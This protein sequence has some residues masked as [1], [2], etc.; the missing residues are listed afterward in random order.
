MCDIHTSQK[1]GSV[2]RGIDNNSIAKYTAGKFKYQSTVLEREVNITN[3]T[4][5]TKNF[6]YIKL[7]L[8]HKYT[9]DNS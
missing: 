1:V 4:D 5:K 6:P 8:L 3:T 9:T 2:Y 7:A